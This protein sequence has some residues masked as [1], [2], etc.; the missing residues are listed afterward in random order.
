MGF[1]TFHW[2]GALI[3]IGI[4]AGASASE[5]LATRRGLPK[6]LVWDGLWW[7]LVPGIVGARLYHVAD[8]WSE[9][10]SQDPL[11]IFRIWEGGLAIWGGIVGG[12]LGLWVYWKIRFKNYDL[13]FM[14]LLDLVF[15][16]LPLGQVIGRVG[17]FVNQEV[18]G[19]PS[20]LPWAIRIDPEHRLPGF[21]SF[22]RFHPLFSYE[23]IVGLLGFLGMFGVEKYYSKLKKIPLVSSVSHFVYRSY[24]GFYLAWY[25]A[26]RFFLEF[27]R[28]DAF[29]WTAGP[30]NLSQVLSAGAVLA[31][32]LLLVI[33]P[34]SEPRL[35]R[36]VSGQRVQ[37]R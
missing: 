5:W 20:S 1:F 35:Q 30:I 19:L 6:N 14:N 16:G 26:V 29:V 31:G 37:H 24:A 36:S 2:Y 27:L 3:G 13:R 10:Y 18:Y 17:N 28:P 12:L 15:F 34:Q 25:G 32:L 22:E 33:V 9:I 7:A 4:L 11:S 21:E 23:V 8:L